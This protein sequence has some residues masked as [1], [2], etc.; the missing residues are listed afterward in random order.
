MNPN[1]FFA[2]A[3]FLGMFFFL[4]AIWEVIDIM[5]TPKMTGTGKI[6]SVTNKNDGNLVVEV[7]FADEIHKFII[8]DNP[9]ATYNRNDEVPI[10]YQ[11]GRVSDVPKRISF[12]GFSPNKE[13]SVYS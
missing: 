11:C 1:T 2:V 4:W 13:K 7:S 5:G 9:S 12:N 6:I 10:V 3:M 8:P